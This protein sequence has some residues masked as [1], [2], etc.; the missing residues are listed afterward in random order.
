LEQK[1]LREKE[2]LL[3]FAEHSAIEAVTSEINQE[4]SLNQHIPLAGS[5]SGAAVIISHTGAAG[6][7][8]QSHHAAFSSRRLSVSSVGSNGDYYVPHSP[9]LSPRHRSNSLAVD[10]FDEVTAAAT[11]ASA[12]HNKSPLQQ[13]M[14]QNYAFPQGSGFAPV[15]P[16]SA[17]SSGSSSSGSG[18]VSPRLLRNK[19]AS[20]T[21]STAAAT[22]TPVFTINKQAVTNAAAQAAQAAGSPSSPRVAK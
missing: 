8:P 12:A 14:Q 18:M 9:R 6:S 13:M 16:R 5:G 4:R 22:V 2:K 19:S 11:I 17:N 20:D 21:P 15:S 1:F 7:P 10:H 3:E